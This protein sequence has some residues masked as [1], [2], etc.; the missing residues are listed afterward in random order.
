MLSADNAALEQHV[1]AHRACTR[2]C[3][4]GFIPRAN[5]VTSLVVSSR[6]L[7]VG[8]APG[9]VEADVT[10]PFAGRAGRQLMRWFARAGIGDEAEVRRRVSLTSVTTCFPGRNATGTGDRRPSVAEIRLCA[11]WLDG[12]LALVKPALILPVGG[13]AH[14]RFLPNRRLDD[15]IGRVFDRDGQEVDDP[16][17]A[18]TVPVLLPLPHPSG[19]SRW[20]NE[21]TRVML[22][23]RALERLGGL[24]TWA[25]NTSRG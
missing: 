18:S 25:E 17:R 2:C 5:P 20:L 6:V 13:L 19:Q 7:L 11:P 21:P 10:R 8:Q 12:A 14:S 24:M 23:E 9:P 3:V 1:R 16:S 4:A 22:L 15:L